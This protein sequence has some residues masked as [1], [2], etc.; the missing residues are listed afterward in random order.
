MN[1]AVYRSCTLCWPAGDA[2]SKI[3]E[4][5]HT[6]TEMPDIGRACQEVNRRKGSAIN[7]TVRA[8]A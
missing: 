4:R 6:T 1:L 5:V 2:P 3:I 7:S 8:P